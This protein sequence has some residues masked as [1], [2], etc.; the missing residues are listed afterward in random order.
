MAGYR[1]DGSIPQTDS[2]LTPRLRAMHERLFG[3]AVQGLAPVSDA[4]MAR[5]L[6]DLRSAPELD[7]FRLWLVGSRVEP[8]K[9]SSDIDIVLSPRLAVLPGDQLVENALLYCREYGLYGGTSRCVIDAFF[10]AEGPTVALTPLAPTAL[11]RSVKLYSPRVVA[12][13][14]QRR[15]EQWRRVG[16]VSIEFVRWAVDTDYYRKL[17]RRDFDGSHASYL[18]PAIEIFVSNGNSPASCIN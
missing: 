15:I 13:L 11:I 6:H 3:S 10:R 1:A 9:N 7:S 16:E 14:H 12:V 4:E 5:V 2:T 8:G 17:P 18:R